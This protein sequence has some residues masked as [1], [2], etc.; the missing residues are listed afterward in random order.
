MVESTMAEEILDLTNQ[1]RQASGLEAL[2]LDPRLTDAAQI[3]ASAMAALDVLDHTLP[4]MPQPTLASRLQFVGYDYAWAAEN[5]AFGASDAAAVVSLWMSS[6]PHAT[7]ILSPEATATGIGV[8]YD[9][10]GAPY[11]S[12]VFGELQPQ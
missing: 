8:A 7:N 9:S 6:P 10:T 11:Y 3:Q 4:S 1:A 2:V 5:I 12:Q